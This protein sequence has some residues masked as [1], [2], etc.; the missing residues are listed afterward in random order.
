MRDKHEDFWTEGGGLTVNVGDPKGGE[1]P[2]FIWKCLPTDFDLQVRLKRNN[3]WESGEAK[4]IT[5]IAVYLDRDDELAA[6]VKALRFTA[7]AVDDLS[8][9]KTARKPVRKTSPRPTRN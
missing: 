5:A 3:E 1:I 4:A 6:L 7:D 2:L 8:A 9:C